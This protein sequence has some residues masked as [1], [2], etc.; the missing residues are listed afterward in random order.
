VCYCGCY[1][2]WWGLQLTWQLFWHLVVVGGGGDVALWSANVLRWRRWG[3]GWAAEA[4]EHVF[5]KC[6]LMLVSGGQ[7]S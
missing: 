5:P 6:C 2:I 4:R 3:W 1:A 7:G